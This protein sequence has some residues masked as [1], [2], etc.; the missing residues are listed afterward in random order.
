MKGQLIF[1]KSPE[2]VQWQK[3]ILKN[4]AETTRYLNNK[5]KTSPVYCDI[6]TN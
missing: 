2:I 6:H 5:K 4:G 1:G 3:E